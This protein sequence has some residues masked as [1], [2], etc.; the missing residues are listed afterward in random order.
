MHQLFFVEYQNFAELLFGF[1]LKELTSEESL[2]RESIVLSLLNSMLPLLKKEKQSETDYGTNHA[3]KVRLF[4]ETNYIYPIKM[5]EIAEEIHISEKHMYRLFMKRYQI[6]PQNF[7]LQT[8]MNTA[9]T[10]LLQHKFPVKEVALSVGYTSLP[11]FSKA[12]SNYFGISPSSFDQT[13][14]ALF[15]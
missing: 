15:Y 6:S 13:E 7:L 4:I 11:S 12:F 8:R 14:Y 5:S 10:L 2:N 3:E 1:V 9:K